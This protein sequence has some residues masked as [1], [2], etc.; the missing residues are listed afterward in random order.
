MRIGIVPLLALA[1]TE[2]G[3]STQIDDMP[4]QPTREREAQILD[5]I[6]AALKGTG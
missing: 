1:F 5:A 4:V 2:S 6:E 3:C